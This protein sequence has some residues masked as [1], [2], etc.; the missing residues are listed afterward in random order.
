MNSD[1]NGFLLSVLYLPKCAIFFGSYVIQHEAIKYE[2]ES[3]L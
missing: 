1:G 3:T 2:N